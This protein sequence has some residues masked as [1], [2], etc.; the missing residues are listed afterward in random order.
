MR[1]LTS[2]ILASLCI[3]CSVHAESSVSLSKARV[4]IET[5]AQ[6]G[7]AFGVEGPTHST[8]RGVTEIG[9]MFDKMP[10]GSRPQTAFGLVLY[11]A[12][13]DE[14]FRLG[15]KPK[16]RYRF[17]PKWSTDISAGYMF[18]SME[19]GPYVSQTGI[20]GGITLNYSSWLSFKGDV[21]V[22]NVEDRPKNFVGEPVGII[23]GGRE[24]SVYGGVSLRSRPGVLATI[25]GTSI[26]LAFAVIV[27]AEGGRS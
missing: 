8:F 21:N 10:D 7:G 19:S 27:M 5:G 12:I 11:G 17:R 1:F 15:I 13:G 3:P 23:E 4:T 24:I 18:A 6:A 22:V 25:V 26:F 16:L 20:I 9:L 14:D 2:F